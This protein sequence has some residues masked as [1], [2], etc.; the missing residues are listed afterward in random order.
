MPLPGETRS[1]VGG[2]PLTA[3]IAVVLAFLFAIRE[4]LLPFILA[5]AIAFILTPLVDY[6]ER[7]FHLRRWAV[8]AAVYLT[9]LALLAWLMIWVGSLVFR[10][11]TAIGRQLPHTVHKLV[12][13]LVQADNRFIG[14]S[15]NPDM[16]TNE[17]LNQA[18]SWFGSG[19]LVQYVNYSVAAIFGTI[20]LLV[21]L[22]YF[23]F[24]GR[25]LADGAF[26]LIPPEYRSSVRSVADRI[27]P[28]L[29]RYF[30]GLVAVVI[31]TSLA[32]WIGFGAIF[33]LPHAV[34]L[35]LVVGLLE[36]VPV[37][38]PAVSIGLILLTAVQESSL[39]VMI[40]LVVFI[41]V[42][43]LTIDQLVGPLVLGRAARVHPVVIIFA[44][45]S[46]AIL[47]GIIGLLLA[48]P[49]AASI[50]IVLEAYYD[51]PLREEPAQR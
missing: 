5:A 39:Y 27:L 3:A 42:L 50:K 10:D 14:T 2:W 18:K 25:R 4:I 32:A 46:G 22:A 17:V 21:L 49:V 12:S 34:L 6:L 20:L 31:Y 8:A 29:W 7:R 51:E 30:V 28:L 13:D 26:W 40:G 43:R 33:H 35:A 23:L 15:M 24:S 11:L 48:V 38:G 44:F 37:I 41:I 1:K 19:A 36:L 16:V 9:L 47:F 45:L